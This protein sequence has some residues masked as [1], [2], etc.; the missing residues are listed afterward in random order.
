MAYFGFRGKRAVAA[1]LLVMAAT[2]CR[3]EG[4]SDTATT[5]RVGIEMGTTTT[6]SRPITPE[7]RADLT[8]RLI[9]VSGQCLDASQ[10]RVRVFEA[11]DVVK[12]TI[13]AVAGRDGKFEA[14][15]ELDSKPI[16]VLHATAACTMQVNGKSLTLTSAAVEVSSALGTSS[17]D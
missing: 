2:G 4:S 1:G 9:H 15:G 13:P 5:Y 10:V 7:L 14:S 17:T 11:E 8:G 3:G 12:L 6:Q 16:F